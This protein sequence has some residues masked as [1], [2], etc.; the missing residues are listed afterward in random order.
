[1]FGE[2]ET[3]RKVP[4]F[5]LAKLL[6]YNYIDACAVFRKKIWEDIGGY[7]EM[8]SRLGY[9]DW[10][11]WLSIAAQGWQFFHVNETL[12]EYRVRNNSMIRSLNS[13]QHELLI[14][15]IYKKHYRLIQLALKKITAPS[16][17]CKGINFLRNSCQGIFK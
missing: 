6:L 4:S 8:P 1:M 16:L 2:Q 12:F 5:N 7:T 3:H 10:D 11:I 17:F 14:Q 15:Y 9:E 13:E